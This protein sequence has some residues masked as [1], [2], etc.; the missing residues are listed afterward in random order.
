[1][2]KT[3]RLLAMLL[4]LMLCMGEIS[5]TGHTVFAAGDEEETEDVCLAPVNAVGVTKDG[6]KY[7]VNEDG[8]TV[9]I[10][11]YEQPGDFK[12]GQMLNLPDIVT[13]DGE[14]LKV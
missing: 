8:I 12:Q 14:E 2:K 9:T 3:K 10:T 5:S 4:T 6:F 7:Q 1:M 11:G 13:V